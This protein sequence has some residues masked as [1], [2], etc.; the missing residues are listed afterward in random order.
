MHE[1]L[2]FFFRTRQKQA[3]S[4]CTLYRIYILSIHAQDVL[5]HIILLEKYCTGVD[6]R[7]LPGINEWW[8]KSTF[9]SSGGGMRRWWVHIERKHPLL[10]LSTNEILAR[11]MLYFYPRLIPLLRV[12]PSIILS[13]THLAVAFAT[14]HS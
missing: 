11:G 3:F 10:T 2:Y 13:F 12:C 14:I 9:K 1:I 7:A 6:S 5:G 4:T 8:C